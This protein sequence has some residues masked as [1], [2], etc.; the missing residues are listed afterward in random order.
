MKFR[1]ALLI[2]M[3]CSI[4]IGEAKASH[5]MGGEITW[6]CQGN[7][8]YIFTMKLYRDC[9]GVALNTNVFLRVHNHPTISTISMQLLSDSDISPQCNGSGPTI[10]CVTADG[11]DAGAVEEFIFRSNSI[12]LPGVPPPQGWIFTFDDCCRNL[13]ISNLTIDGTTGFT[14]R[15][16]MYAY[17]GAN[18][19]PCFD[20]S[21]VFA[22]VPAVIICAGNAFTYNHNAYDVDKDSLVYSFGQ[23]LDWLNG[24]AWVLGVSP[25][26]II[27]DPTY[28]IDSPFPGP[29]LGT[30]PS[31]PATLNNATGEISF[32]SN[33]TGNFVTVISVKSYR[34]GT[35]VSE[36]F[37]EIQVVVIQCSPNTAPTVTAP[38]VNVITGQ[39]TSFI[40]TVQAGELVS[41]TITA[42]DNEFLPIGIAQTISVAASGGQFGANFND[43]SSGCAF[44]P[45]ATLNPA[46]PT[47]LANNGGI[48]FNWQTTCDHVNF[49][50]DCYVPSNTYT[51]VL[52]FQDD[53]CPAPAY[54][55]ATVAVVV[56]APPILPPPQLRCTEVQ[57]NGNVVLSWIPITDPDGIFNAYM[58][59]SSAAAGG[60]Y[61][62]IDS[63]LNINQTNAT[64]TG[65]NA[66]NA[67]VYYRI[68]TRSS[69]GGFGSVLSIASNTIATMFLSTTDGGSGQINIDWT[70]LSNPLLTTSVLPYTLN[71]QVL[72]AAL[73]FFATSQTNSASDFMQG[74]LQTINYQVSLTDQSGCISRSNIN[75]GD[76]SNDQAPDAPVLDSISVNP[77]NNSVYVGWTA[78][79]AND[80]RAYVIYQTSNGAII[81]VD[82]VFGG[83][84]E[85]FVANSRNPD[86][87]S[88]SFSIAAIDS[89]SNLSPV[90]A[91]H[92]TIFN[93][94]DLSS[95]ENKVELL[96][97]AYQGFTVNSYQIFA[98][99]DA[100]NYQLQTSLPGSATN[101]IQNNL[102]PSATYCFLVQAIGAGGSSTSNEI[103]FLANVQDLPEFAYLRKATVTNEGFAYSLCYIDTASD[104]AYYRIKRAN[105]PDTNF[106][107]IATYP[108]PVNSNLVDFIDYD[109]A[110]SSQA[111][112]YKYYLVD[113]CENESMISN[114][115]R[116]MLLRGVAGDGFV[117]R[118]RWNPYFDWDADVDEYNIYRSLDKGI[119]YELIATRE[120]DTTLIDPVVNEV[121]TV[122]EFCYYLEAIE[123]PGNQYGFRDT[124]YSNVVCVT[125][126]PTIY[127]P[128]AFRPTNL[129][130]N[131]LFK[132]VG[133]Y[134]TLAKN[135]EFR[136]FNRWG[137][138][139]FFTKDT[140]EPW[141]GKY[142][143]SYVQTGVY[144]YS[145]RFRFPDGS[146]YNVR[147]SVLV[148]D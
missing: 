82:T 17:N 47:I 94:Y 122:L 6:A 120:T 60:P 18:T 56:E 22:Q 76:F 95:C 134:E 133:L 11:N 59:Y 128:N 58:I 44:P 46:P 87:A 136:I 114:V 125:Q 102:I 27:F 131:N 21:P 68:R 116:T 147:G 141:D 65:T 24:A 10:S 57:S 119:N 36:I 72:P 92:T 100:G 52:Q 113:K 25:N 139:L 73:A 31:I 53:A 74:C 29:S 66:N 42:T 111:Y 20:S 108:I 81:Q 78:S 1:I 97:T 28:S 124:S 103:C 12:N 67:P 23:P 88:V 63:V 89:C 140:K 130:G 55:I 112:S 54:K 35:L 98:K 33:Y 71:K 38:F 37:R 79:L 126:R 49:S 2:F 144:V 41:F 77:A 39:Q 61:V 110:T 123:N 146:L 64:L 19:S 51:F 4:C 142:M 138:Q 14:L 83:N 86:L 80:V 106:V 105:Y 69:C 132:P 115:G 75:G 13:A 32:T 90:S 91:V 43:P 8:N 26:S 50:T 104:A 127:I 99:V 137:E 121:D 70:T 109:A 3:F 93:R 107:T 45:C 16:V 40:D 148:L 145:V 96:F 34:C 135:H 129:A 84:V 143:N 101:Y 118:L 7:G 62:L 5:L 117:N 85:A 15:A 9:N 48:T 30:P